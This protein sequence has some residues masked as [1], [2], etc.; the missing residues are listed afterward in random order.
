MRHLAIAIMLTACSPLLNLDPEDDANKTNPCEPTAGDRGAADCALGFWCNPATSICERGDIYLPVYRIMPPSYADTCLEDEVNTCFDGRG[1]CTVSRREL[2]DDQVEVRD[3]DIYQVT[4]ENGASCTFMRVLFAGTWDWP[5]VFERSWCVNSAPLGRK[6]C[7]SNEI[8]SIT[9]NTQA[10]YSVGVHAEGSRG[11]LA[12]APRGDTYL[13]HATWRFRCP[14]GSE[15]H[16]YASSPMPDPPWLTEGNARYDLFSETVRSYCPKAE[17]VL[18]ANWEIDGNIVPQIPITEDDGFPGDIVT[19]DDKNVVWSGVSVPDEGI[20]EVVRIDRLELKRTNT[21]PKM[22]DGGLQLQLVHS[23]D[24]TT[25]NVRGM[26]GHKDSL[27][28]HLGGQ[29]W[30]DDHCS[31]KLTMDLAAWRASGRQ[32]IPTVISGCNLDS[33]IIL[34]AGAHQDCRAN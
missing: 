21:L 24:S 26:L 3:G 34:C 28:L 1:R 12:I 16:I 29:M 20:D 17:A 13:F 15:Q 23:G 2:K 32:Q 22:I 8:S 10:E 14:G 9:A 5:D 4:W 30:K 19:G 25:G 18:L 31:P 27:V 11:A 33:T 6:I 7:V